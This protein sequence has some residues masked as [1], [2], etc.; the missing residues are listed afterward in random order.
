MN[1]RYSYHSSLHFIGCGND[2]YGIHIQKK[3]GTD[4]YP[5]LIIKCKN[6]Q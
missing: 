6:S 4:Y 1:L 5:Q 3:D 2:G